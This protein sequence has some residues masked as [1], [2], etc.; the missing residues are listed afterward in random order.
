MEDKVAPQKKPNLPKS[1]PRRKKLILT[2]AFIFIVLGLLF[3]L[4]W[5]FVGRFHESTDDSY[6]DGNQVRVMSQIAGIV[7][8]IL[9]DETDLV[10]EGNPIIKLE[11]T[12]ADVALKNAEDQLALIVRQVNQL[13][14]NV[15]QLEANLEQ[16]ETLLQRA[17]E[18]YQ[19]RQGLTVNKTISE[20]DL[21]HSKIAVDTAIDAVT[22]AKDQL[23]SAIGLVG[24][25]DLY[26]H[27]QIQ[28]AIE[29][30]RTAF[31]TYQRTTIFA[32]ETGYVAKRSVQVGQQVKTDTVLMIIVPLDQLWVNAN[33]KE[34]QLRHIR[35]GQPAEMISDAYG[36]NVKYHGKVIGL[37]PGTGSAFDLLPPQN[38]TGNWIKIVQRLPV[39]I[40]IDPS[41][42]EKH[43]L[44]IGL[45][46]DVTVDTHNRNGELLTLVPQTKVVYQT[47]DYSADLKKANETINKILQENAVDVTLPSS[48][49]QRKD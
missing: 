30:V 8:Q 6:V 13:Y 24:T 15:Q 28:Q 12:D 29:N 32:P 48:I 35:I 36:S 19:R 7:V 4:Y 3:F 2:F 21:R 41:Q 17:K 38:A 1:N 34:S 16:Q 46:M 42:L 23:Q 9:A 10:K 22:S 31:L 11:K 45:S 47:M 27:P 39:R 37:N 14:K 25:T 44:R 20:E 49:L 40:S 33:F 43:P 26:H 18:D 5:L